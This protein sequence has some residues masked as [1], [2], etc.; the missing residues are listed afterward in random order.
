MEEEKQKTD[1]AEMEE[2][3]GFGETLDQK[4]INLNED[5]SEEDRA[6]IAPDEETPDT[7]Y[8]S[9]FGEDLSSFEEDQR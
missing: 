7:S 5:I 8:Q 9:G 1:S 4:D 3:Q 6:A 2:P